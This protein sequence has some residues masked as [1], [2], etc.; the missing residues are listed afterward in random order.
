[1]S[2]DSDRPSG[3]DDL[4]G[5][6]REAVADREGMELVRVN[7][8]GP[9]VTVVVEVYADTDDGRE[10]TET[11]L[12]DVHNRPVPE[13]DAEL[14]PDADDLEWTYLGPVEGA[15]GSGESSPS[16]GSTNEK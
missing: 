4:R 3:E 14:L 5:C 10:L 8:D 1:M 7:A 9:E 12:Y 11:S 6:I 13:G 16:G 2:D 15:E